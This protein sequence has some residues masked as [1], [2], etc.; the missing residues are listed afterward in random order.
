M[1]S[2]GSNKAGLGRCPVFSVFGSCSLPLLRLFVTQFNAKMFDL[3]VGSFNKAR[4]GRFAVFLF[5]FWFCSRPFPLLFFV[6]QR[7]SFR[8][9]SVFSNEVKLCRFPVFLFFFALSLPLPLLFLASQRHSFWSFTAFDHVV[10][11]VILHIIFCSCS[12]PLPLFS[13]RI[14]TPILLSISS[15]G[16]NKTKLSRFTVFLLFSLP[17]L[18]SGS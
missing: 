4:L 9:S 3:V 10:G 12:L 6:S 1:P 16:S 17:R 7:H 13:F 11:L 14:P 15:A 5:L 18:F 8:S 2:A